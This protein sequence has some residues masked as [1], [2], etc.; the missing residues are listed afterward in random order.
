MPRKPPP[1]VDIAK[2]DPLEAVEYV[3]LL[4]DFNAEGRKSR[5]PVGAAAIRDG[6]QAVR[7]VLKL[8]RRAQ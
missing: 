5:D 7:D 2:S 4:L 8:P 3:L 1:H 6:I